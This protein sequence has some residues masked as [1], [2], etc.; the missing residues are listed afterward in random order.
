[1][2]NEEL[3]YLQREK[4]IEAFISELKLLVN[5]HNISVGE[6]DN[7]DGEDLYCGTDYYFAVDGLVWYGKTIPEFL[8]GII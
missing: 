2:N 3:E 5:K 6:S 8:K 7:Y 1:M 4:K